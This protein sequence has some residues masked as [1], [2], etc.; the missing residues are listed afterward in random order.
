MA[1]LRL[2]VAA[3]GFEPVRSGQILPS[4]CAQLLILFYRVKKK[5]DADTKVSSSYHTKYVNP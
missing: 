2:F 5:E 1:P 3:T 4:S